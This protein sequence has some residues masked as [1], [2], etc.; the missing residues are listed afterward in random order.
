MSDSAFGYEDFKKLKVD[1]LKV[2]KDISH[3]WR[4]KN[5]EMNWSSWVYSFLTLVIKNPAFKDGH[6]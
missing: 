4:E 2:G 1:S 5:D 6:Q 3:V